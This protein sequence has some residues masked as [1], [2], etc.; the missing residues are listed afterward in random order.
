MRG[1]QPP[2]LLQRRRAGRCTP[3]SAGSLRI[4]S[5]NAA[6]SATPRFDPSL[7][8]PIVSSRPPSSG[9]HATEASKPAQRPADPY[10]RGHRAHPHWNDRPAR[11]IAPPTATKDT[12]VRHFCAPL[13]PPRHATVTIER[14]YTDPPGPAHRE[15]PTQPRYVP[16]AVNAVASAPLTRIRVSIRTPAAGPPHRISD[17][18]STFAP[19]TPASWQPYPPPH[20]TPHKPQTSHSRGT[21]P[22]RHYPASSCQLQP[23]RGR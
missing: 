5:A 7:A 2:T 1:R 9:P 20:P 23:G 12:S 8:A 6:I 18:R 22:F 3:L 15:T 13:R 17:R 21:T 11:V 14:P 16:I 10:L 4:R 19:A